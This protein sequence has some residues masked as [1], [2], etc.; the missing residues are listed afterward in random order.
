MESVRLMVKRGSPPPSLPVLDPRKLPYFLFCS[1][2]HL[3]VNY[4]SSKLTHHCVAPSRVPS[5]CAS[6]SY[7]YRLESR[8]SSSNPS[9]LQAHVMHRSVVSKT[10]PSNVANTVRRAVRFERSLYLTLLTYSKTN[11]LAESSLPGL[12]SPSD[13]LPYRD[14]FQRP[15]TQL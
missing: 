5:K 9:L 15:R 4:N 8:L 3:Q 2:P 12:G 10:A 13:F 7:F 11:S 1:E 6:D 14:P